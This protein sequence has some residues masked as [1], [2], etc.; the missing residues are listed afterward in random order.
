[1]NMN[2]LKL[3]Q[4]RIID[5]SYKHKSS[6]LGSCLSALPIILEIYEKKEENDIFVLSNGHAGLALYVV[7]EQFYGYDAEVLFEKFGVHPEH[8][9]NYK[10]YCTGGSLG[11]GITVGVGY[12]LADKNRKTYV[13]LSD[14][15][16]AEGSVWESLKFIYE[17]KIN[18]IELY[19]NAN[20]VSAISFLDLPYL[21][22]CL[23]AF[24][25]H[26]NIRHTNVEVFSF[27]KG[28][29][30]H[31]KVMSEENYKQALNELQ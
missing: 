24:N 28:L 18:N 21:E 8:D 29:E 27:L 1:M 5:I 16:C 17:N 14:G 2:K 31:Y 9:L 11:H 7:L 10:I 6:H 25:P 13:L 30:A 12:A 3:L 4:K 15:E 26:I 20:G 22:S 19:L 23:K